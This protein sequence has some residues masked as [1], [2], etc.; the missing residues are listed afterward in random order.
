MC[1]RYGWVIK[2]GQKHITSNHEKGSRDQNFKA[3]KREASQVGLHEK[4]ESGGRRRLPAPAFWHTWSRS[5]WFDDATC[6]IQ[7]N[8]EVAGE[9]RLL[10]GA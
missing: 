3:E 8:Q 1:Y 7:A 4:S 5:G 9:N 10:P 6:E 2:R